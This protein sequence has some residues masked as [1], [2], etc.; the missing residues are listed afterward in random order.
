MLEAIR[1][2]LEQQ[3]RSQN[4]RRYR[5]RLASTYGEVLVLLNTVLTWPSHS[6]TVFKLWLR[7]IVVVRVVSS[8]SSQRASPLYS[9][10]HR[11]LLVSTVNSHSR[12]LTINTLSSSFLL[13]RALIPCVHLF[14]FILLNSYSRLYSIS[15]CISHLSYSSFALVCYCEPFSNVFHCSCRLFFECEYVTTMHLC[16]TFV[17]ET[18]C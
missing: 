4:A 6:N 17:K 1:A 16:C 12:Y 8:A 10:S 5:Y 14:S 9:V 13:L 2:V 11:F 15:L 18:H 7:L 3:Q